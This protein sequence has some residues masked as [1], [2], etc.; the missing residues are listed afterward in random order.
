VVIIPKKLNVDSG[1]RGESFNLR[2]PKG[3]V[4]LRKP[5]YTFHV[6]FSHLD[7]SSKNKMNLKCVVVTLKE[8]M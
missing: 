6:H 7:S 3:F 4:D 2:A 8:S 5:N 1:K